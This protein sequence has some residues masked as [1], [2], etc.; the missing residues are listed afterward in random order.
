MSNEFIRWV[1]AALSNPIEKSKLLQQP[2]KLQKIMS[3]IPA[4]QWLFEQ[5]CQTDDPDLAIQAKNLIINMMKF[6]RL[7][8]YGAGQISPDIYEEA[9]SRTWEWF[10]KELCL[11]YNPEKASF[12]TWFNRRL[13]FRI[14]DVIREQERERN[15]R[16]HLPPD[17][18][19]NE[20]IFPPAP[21]PES[22]HETIQEWL[23]L[24]QRHSQLRNC[25]MQNHPDINCQFL[26]MQIL[27]ML[28]DSGKF[29]WHSLAQQYKVDQSSLR[30]F[31][32]TRCF[33]IFKQL[34][35]E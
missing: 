23:E 3:D 35:S 18:E 22:W 27:Q 20:W 16:L 8:W 10:N 5:A 7:I 25:R 26:L 24:V 29:S 1:Q 34:L 13:K 32:K 21:E 30:R 15:R 14:L 28:R 9:L 2:Q 12:V 11:A 4:R 17:E 6:S 33:P 31:C 19:N